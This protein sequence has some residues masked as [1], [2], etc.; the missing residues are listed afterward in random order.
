MPGPGNGDPL[1]MLLGGLAGGL[2]QHMFKPQNQNGQVQPGTGQPMILDPATGAPAQYGPITG[3]APSIIDPKT[4]EPVGTP[5]L[6]MPGFNAA[7]QFQPLPLTQ[8]GGSGASGKGNAG[9]GMGQGY[10]GAT[11]LQPSPGVVPLP[12]PPLTMPGSPIYDHLGG[13]GPVGPSVDL[14]Y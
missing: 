2:L 10:Q 11:A 12:M 3:P 5:A 13:N 1:L 9:Y 7:G 14:D 4:G 6:P 8:G